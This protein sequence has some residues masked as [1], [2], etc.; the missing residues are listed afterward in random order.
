MPLDALPENNPGLTDSKRLDIQRKY[1]KKAGLIAVADTKLSAEEEELAVKKKK[2]DELDSA[3]AQ[4]MYIISSETNF[5]I[6][7]TQADT[8]KEIDAINAAIDRLDKTTRGELTDEVGE[9]R[10]ARTKLRRYNDRL[11]THRQEVARAQNLNAM[12]AAAARTQNT[13][14][15][16]QNVMNA[17]QRVRNAPQFNP[18]APLN[19]MRGATPVPGANQQPH[20]PHAAPPPPPQNNNAAAQNAIL[21][22]RLAALA[23]ETDN[24]V[25]TGEF[26]S[27]RNQYGAT[28]VIDNINTLKNNT[29]D[30]RYNIMLA[31]FRAFLNNQNNNNNPAP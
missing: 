23:G 20:N 7:N 3:D 22:A 1:G 2:R 10:K 24:T 13:V 30:Q 18:A 4:K 5:Q 31:S 8:S 25:I 16:A 17:T 19:G 28:E 29:G 21:Q 15:R 14:N 11:D 9:L 27:L 6:A 12:Q 26:R